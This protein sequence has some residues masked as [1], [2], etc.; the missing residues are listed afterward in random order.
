[1]KKRPTISLCL[2]AKNEAHN[3]RAL[4]ESIEG[5]FDEV[6]LVDT[7]ST[8][9]TKELAL[10]YGA[11]VFDFTWVDDFAAAR[12]Y[13]FD[14]A[15]SDYVFWCDLDDS[16]RNKEA[17]IK[18][19]DN[20]MEVADYWI[21]NYHYAFDFH[22]ST[23]LCT[24][25]RER[26]I[27][28]GK[29]FK[30]K[31]FVH[32]GLMPSD[33]VEL[34]P[35][36]IT[37]WDIVHRR[38]IKDVEAD[39]TRNIT[40]FEKNRDKF[41]TRMLYYY[42]KEL[43]ENKLTKVAIVPLSEAFQKEDLA[44]HDRVLCLQYL[45]YSFMEE[46]DFKRAFEL[47]QVGI[48]LDP[49]R[50]EFH[51]A[52]GD[53]KIGLGEIQNAL[54]FYYAAT[55][56]RQNHNLVSRFIFSNIDAYG[57]YP[58]NAIVKVLA[59]M[60]DIEAAL[61]VA[62]QTQERFHHAETD[63][64]LKE[65]TQART[66]QAFDV[67]MATN[68]GDIIFTC[69]ANAY[70]W[71]GE[72]YRKQGL[73]GSET[74]EIELAEWFAKLTPRKIIIFNSVKTE[75]HIN[76]VIYRPLEMLNDYL[77]HNVPW[78]HIAWRHNN[79][80]CNAMTVVHSHDLQTPGIENYNIFEKVAVLTPWHRD[81]MNATQGVPFDKMWLTGNGIVPE[82]FNV[83]KSK[84]DPYAF[85]FSSSPDR[86]LDRAM[87]VLDK[88]REEFPEITLRVFYGIEHL[89][90]YGLK[91]LQD[92]LKAM[93][94]ERP[95][96][97]YYG[98]TEQKEMMRHFK[99]V[100]YCVQPSNFLETFGISVLEQVCSGIYPIFRRIGGIADTLKP[101]VDKGM[102]SLVEGDCVSEAEFSNYIEETKKAVKE[103]RHLRVMVDANELSWK[104]RAIEWLDEFKKLKGE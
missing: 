42:G 95:W 36:M 16:L 52:M 45:V 90:K 100:S 71:D 84:K 104:N 63:L 80:I 7:G 61:N 72:I 60:G 26:I 57:A 32:E 33:G 24:F 92:K 9:N 3:I 15:T 8:D 40:L 20:V 22:T 1:M 101:F 11:K 14:Q 58:W 38:S 82:R 39:R 103:Q 56:C 87:L 2:I 17:F 89:E 59:N 85:V 69:F 68:C 21:A 64:L 4:F 10:S 18:F 77:K 54:P 94:N 41:D 48:N 13:S 55:A 12:N 74:A 50:A 81:F 76:G 96:V 5:C 97:T 91:D 49:H 78:M 44:P 25:P 62:K 93:M 30:W 79:K 73:G 51:V 99:E 35:Q 66:S 27:K 19:R 43:F 83:D 28:R 23:P 67:S 65:L 29:G 6:I 34:K 31:Y 102:A 70:E 98:K 75:K 86:G 37:T 88:V 53:S 46:K 47:A